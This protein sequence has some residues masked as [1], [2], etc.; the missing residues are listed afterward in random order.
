MKM[1]WLMLVV[2]SV[3]T[4]LIIFRIEARDYFI[5]NESVDSFSV[6]VVNKDPRV[7]IAPLNNKTD[8]ALILGC[9]R[10][11]NGKGGILSKKRY[12]VIFE[13]EFTPLPGEEPYIMFSNGVGTVKLVFFSENYAELRSD[14]VLEIHDNPQRREHDNFYTQSDTLAAGNPYRDNP[15]DGYLQHWVVF[16]ERAGRCYT[17][18]YCYEVDRF[19]LRAVDI[20]DGR[21]SASLLATV[22]EVRGCDGV[23]GAYLP[24]DVRL[25]RRHWWPESC[26]IVA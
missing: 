12:S 11:F 15:Y 4:N 8:P 26:C 17:A 9:D 19:A 10:R 25:H 6:S 22:K 14:T 3:A 16:G 24:P 13:E 18:V 5:R 7:I 21:A 1:K 20:C 2:A 23:I